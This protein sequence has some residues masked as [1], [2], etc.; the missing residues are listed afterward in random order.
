LINKKIIWFKNLKP[1]KLRGIISEGMLLAGGDKE[2]KIEVI[3]CKDFEIGDKILIQGIKQEYKKE[4]DFKE[5][6][7]IKFN[8]ENNNLFIN[9]KQ[10]FIENKPIKTEKI[11]EG[12]VS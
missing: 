2:G 11:K 9:G 10:L 4:I 12:K 8:I 7:K 3:D 6:Q 1:A 5:F